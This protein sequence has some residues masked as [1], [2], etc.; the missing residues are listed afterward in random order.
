MEHVD[1]A[2]V[3]GGL[4]GST[5]A[6]MLGRSGINAVMIDPHAV[7]PPD[8][9]C[10]KLDESQIRLLRQTGLADTVLGTATRYDE[11]WIARFGQL[12]ERRRTAQYGVLYE[13]LVNAVRDAIPQGAGFIAAKVAAVSTGADRQ[14]LML[15]NGAELSARLI[16]LANG[17]NSGLRRAVGM[18]REDLS[19]CHSISI[20]FD[21]RPLRGAFDFPSLTYFPELTAGRIAYFTLFPI[22]AGMRANLFV[23]RDSRDPWLHRLREAPQDTL[24]AALPGLRRLTGDFS[25]TNVSKIRPVDLYVTRS[26][27]QPGVVLVGDAF[28]TSCPAAGTGVNKVLTDV[29]QLCAVHIPQWLAS[30]GMPEEKIGAFYDDPIKRACDAQSTDKAYFLR[31]LSTESGIPWRA[32]RWGRFIGQLG[33]SLARQMGERLSPRLAHRHGAEA[34]A[35]GP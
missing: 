16:I 24:F 2:I 6:A 22:G 3:G 25:A 11:I 17:L 19:A 8:F 5:A 28:S 15:S 10:E 31:S 35:A 1:V 23:Y 34:G 20:G 29:V 32:R 30:P 14:R 7:Y 9:R 27:R 12:V 18:V 33:F 4:A 26:W 21:A 13:T